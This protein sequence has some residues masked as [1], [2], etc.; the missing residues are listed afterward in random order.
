MQRVAVD[1]DGKKLF[2]IEDYKTDIQFKGLLSR[3]TVL[4]K[5]DK[6]SFLG[7]ID[8]SLQEVSPDILEANIDSSELPSYE[9]PYVG[10]SALSTA[11]EG[12]PADLVVGDYVAFADKD[13][14]SWL[15]G[16]ILEISGKSCTIKKMKR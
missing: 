1:E 16:T 10:L 8:I 4:Y 14:R 12:V 2:L 9:D 11:L 5:S 3:L 13:T 7:G 15:P 6:S